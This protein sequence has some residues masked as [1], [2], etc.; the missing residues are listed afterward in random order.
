MFRSFAGSIPRSDILSLVV[1]YWWKGEHWVPVKGF[2]DQPRKS[3]VIQT[4]PQLFSK[5][6]KQEINPKVYS[7]TLPHS[8]LLLPYLKPQKNWPSYHYRVTLVQDLGRHN[9]LRKTTAL[10]KTQNVTDITCQQTYGLFLMTY[11]LTDVAKIKVYK[12]N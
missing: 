11:V 6:V 4:W 3:E 12:S 10:W 7:Y 9:G 1:S 2:G 5:D 8:F